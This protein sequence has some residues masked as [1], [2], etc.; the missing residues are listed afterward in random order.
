MNCRDLTVALRIL[1]CEMRT[2]VGTRND[3][4]ILG[5]GEDDL[6]QV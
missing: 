4:R 3:G 2:D 1:V 6:I 5:K